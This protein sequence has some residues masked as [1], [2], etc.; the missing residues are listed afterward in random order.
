MIADN[1][2][3]SG[4]DLPQLDTHIEIVTPENIA[5][6]YRVAGPFRRLGAYAIDVAIIVALAIAASIA[7]T[8]SFGFVGLWGMG[9]GLFLI[10]LFVLQWFYFGAF[11]A[12]WYGQTPGKR[13]T[14]LRVLAFDGQPINGAQAILRNLLRAT[15]LL[16]GNYLLGLVACSLNNRYQR[17]GDLAAGTMVVV[18]E[19]PWLYGVVR[20]NEPEVLRLAG[21]LP[22]NFRVGRS[23]ARAISS[24]V[25][26]RKAFAPGRRAEIARP[27]G[28]PLRV[29]F[30]L[31]QGTSHDL[32]LCALYYQTFIA[33]TPH[34]EM[35]QQRPAMAAPGEH[36][37]PVVAPVGTAGGW[38][39]PAQPRDDFWP[40]NIR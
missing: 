22:A 36:R 6:R 12:L 8:V 1:R 2:S 18:E 29:Q 40:T 23:M 27:L 38:A 14:G 16:P 7:L 4:R 19:K 33:N 17:L 34:D 5:F 26:R 21:Y 30:H 31:P 24:Y 13:L 25:E 3:E 9:I 15:D 35:R 39:P 32:L 37:P 10:I 20:M 28:E 11:E